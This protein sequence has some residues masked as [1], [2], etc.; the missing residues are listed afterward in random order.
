MYGGT[1]MKGDYTWSNISVK[2][3]VGLSAGG[4]GGGGGIRY[5]TLCIHLASTD[6]KKPPIN[7]AE[8]FLTLGNHFSKY[9]HKF[10]K[11]DFLFSAFLMYELCQ[12]SVRL[13]YFRLKQ[14]AFF[15]EFFIG[16]GGGVKSVVL[17]IFLLF[18]DQ[19]LKRD[20][21]S[22]GEG[23]CSRGA[24]PAPLWRKAGATQVMLHFRMTFSQWKFPELLG[25]RICQQFLKSV[26]LS[27]S[28]SLTVSPDGRLPEAFLQKGVSVI[29]GH[30]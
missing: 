11:K 3:K 9:K 7:H 12:G 22:E 19:I 20:K 18:S 8:R 1:Y 4:G 29:Q 13:R 6:N 21:V 14:L 26:L 16:G 17:L 25:W 23:N 28:R 2:E 24:S 30:L 27:K 5:Y 15:Q 10:F